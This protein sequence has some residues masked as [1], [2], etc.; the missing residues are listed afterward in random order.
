MHTFFFIF[1]A[2]VAAGASESVHAAM[3]PAVRPK[4]SIDAHR[5]ERLDI[6]G[7]SAAGKSTLVK[8]GDSTMMALLD[9]RDNA[10]RIHAL[11]TLRASGGY[12]DLRLAVGCARSIKDLQRVIAASPLW[13]LMIFDTELFAQTCLVINYDLLNTHPELKRKK[14]VA[15]RSAFARWWMPDYVV[16]FFE[17]ISGARLAYDG[18]ATHGSPWSSDY[19]TL[20]NISPFSSVT[21]ARYSRAVVSR[22]ALENAWYG[23]VD[24]KNIPEQSRI[25][26]V[27]DDF[28]AEQQCDDGAVVERE[29]LRA[30]IVEAVKPEY[31]S[32]NALAAIS[33]A[34]VQ[35]VRRLQLPGEDVFP[36]R[37]F[38]NVFDINA[39]ACALATATSSLSLNVW[40]SAPICEVR[41]ANGIA[42]REL[43]VV[44]HAAQRVQRVYNNARGVAL[45][46]SPRVRQ[47]VPQNENILPPAL[48]DCSID[49]HKLAALLARAVHNGLPSSASNARSVYALEAPHAVNVPTQ[50]L[51][52]RCL[53]SFWP[54]LYRKRYHFAF[55]GA[56]I[57]AFG[58]A[59]WLSRGAF[60]IFGATSPH[61]VGDYAL[62]AHSTRELKLT[63]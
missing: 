25:V 20:S 60:G 43:V 37:F 46:K 24:L 6:Y 63:I 13:P 45:K 31:Q 29:E 33:V 40:E 58:A 53:S 28:C 5:F 47:F 54:F 12:D 21:P 59:Y 62:E 42:G 52:R 27:D 49:I 3:G 51:W 32:E 41:P 48:W 10:D 44:P 4:V 9:P 8:R 15:L 34:A 50:P 38:P 30:A 61:P 19:A 7:S 39:L 17:A 18:Y 57:G 36:S 35:P 22:E 14:I 2:A 16:G 56:A 23:R 55:V 26:C 11:A 1:L